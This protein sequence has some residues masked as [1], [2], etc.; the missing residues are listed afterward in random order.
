[1]DHAYF[2]DRLSALFD[3]E[4]PPQEKQI[5]EEHVRD[6]AECQSALAKL[7]QLED[8]VKRHSE[9]ADTDYW[10]KSA[11]KIE[12]QLGF[13]QQ[14]IITPIRHKWYEQGLAWKALA[15]AASLAVLAYIGLN[16]DKIL[17]QKELE[18]SQA[19]IERKSIQPPSVAP[20]DVPRADSAPRQKAEPTDRSV[21]STKDVVAG[22]GI[23]TAVSQ[24]KTKEPSL[25][26]KK[27]SLPMVDRQN[28]LRLD[29]KVRDT[30]EA[31]L[32][33]PETK[34][35]TNGLPERR[36]AVAPSTLSAESIRTVPDEAVGRLEEESKE[37]AVAQI[38]SA[39]VDS[40]LVW[41]RKKRDALE[42][43]RSALPGD[44]AIGGLNK[45]A[46]PTTL[47]PAERQSPQQTRDEVEKQLLE[48][49]YN[50]ARL[51]EDA[52]ERGEAVAEI[53]KVADQRRSH[54]HTVAVDYLRQLGE[55]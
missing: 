43:V 52:D 49:W 39:V 23:D 31:Y 26:A 53:R 18:P 22:K 19:P 1:M 21:E 2:K 30:V 47:K 45:M 25:G 38:D 17:R 40:M 32:P 5:V 15:A 42:T 12:R 54:N 29:Q 48:A 55:E 36:I 41:W 7:R 8:A 3:N 20:L 44:D 11:Q 10:E 24:G 4:L 34:I 14:T 33:P 13:D 6:C 35:M 9:L 16:S 27:I 51:T 46:A 50:I 37:A 28:V